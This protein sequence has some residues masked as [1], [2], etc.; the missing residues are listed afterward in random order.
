M[1][2]EEIA[3]FIYHFPLENLLT[4]IENQAINGVTVIR[5]HLDEQDFIKEQ[6]GWCDEE[7]LQLTSTLFQHQ[8]F[9]KDEFLC[10]MNKVLKEGKT[11]QAVLPEE[12]INTI[13]N[14]ISQLDVELLHFEIKEAHNIKYFSDIC[15]NMVDMLIQNNETNKTNNNS[16][17][18]VQDDFVR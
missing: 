15:V 2:T 3:D 7:I 18:Y 6:T 16:I 17:V 1:T 12:L 9:T 10:N 4:R 5:N 13:K 14:T 8:S 11:Q